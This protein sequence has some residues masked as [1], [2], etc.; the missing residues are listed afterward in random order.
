MSHEVKIYG[1]IHGLAMDEQGKSANAGFCLT[2]GETEKEIEY[3][4][5]TAN[6]DIEKLL[7]VLHLADIVSPDS[8]ELITPE[9][10]VREF[11]G[12]DSS[13]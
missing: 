2:L 1:K 13:E 10:Y 9:E 4:Q 3:S 7:S 8:L 6:V 12:E 5:L 11:G